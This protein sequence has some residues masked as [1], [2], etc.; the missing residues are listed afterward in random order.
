MRNAPS[1]GILGR[2][3]SQHKLVISSQHVVDNI[4]KDSPSNYNYNNDIGT[5]YKISKRNNIGSMAFSKAKR[6]KDERD[7][8]RSPQVESFSTHIFKHLPVNDSL[9]L[10]GNM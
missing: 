8:S 10:L 9:E 3:D 2:S 5:L 4:G 1:F 6:F 7:R